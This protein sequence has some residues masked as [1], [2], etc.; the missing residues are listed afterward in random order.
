MSFF[1]LLWVPLFYLFW[2]SIAWSS[3]SRGVWAL[4][5]GSITSII[6][7]FLGYFISPGGFGYSR[8]FFGFTDIV[9]VPVLVPLFVYAFL[10]LIRGTKG[11]VDFAS[12]SL[13]WMIP[14]AALRALNWS[15]AN[16]PVLLITV[17]LLWTALAAGIHFLINLI[18]VN[19]RW[20]KIIISVPCI[21]VLPVIAAGSYWAFFS[22]QTHIG[23]GLLFASHIPLIFSFIFKRITRGE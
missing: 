7:F 12:F 22:Q 13:L 14:F 8:F 19:F 17:P 10:L 16:N 11:K 18:I 9:S 3:G 4:L 21:L 5:L 23:L 1:C 6:Q 15:S 20:Y 2:R